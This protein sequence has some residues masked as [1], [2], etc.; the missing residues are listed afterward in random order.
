MRR[1]KS[2]TRVAKVID[3]PYLPESKA[4]FII[5]EKGIEDSEKEAEEAEEAEGQS[6]NL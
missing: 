2:G 3:S 5:T 6:Q 4:S 1:G